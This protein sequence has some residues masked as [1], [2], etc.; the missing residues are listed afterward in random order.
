MKD[1]SL[2]ARRPVAGNRVDR[3]TLGF[4]PGTRRYWRRFFGKKKVSI[5]WVISDDISR[6][7][8]EQTQKIRGV[9]LQ[10]SYPQ[11]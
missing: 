10:M 9:T 6:Y 11:V 1:R 2:K 8:I 5:A 3:M 7:L 4:A